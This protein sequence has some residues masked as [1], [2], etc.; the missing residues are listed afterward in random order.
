MEGNSLEW[1]E[2]HE[3]AFDPLAD[4]K[5]GLTQ[6]KSL[7]DGISRVNTKS[8]QLLR[9]DVLFFDGDVVSKK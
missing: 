7:T 2:F 1:G 6:K 3:K 4:N 8:K 5:E 9:F